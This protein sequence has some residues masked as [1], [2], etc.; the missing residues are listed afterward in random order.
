[1]KCRELEE[2]EGTTKYR[3]V[4]NIKEGAKKVP[5]ENDRRKEIPC[6]VILVSRGY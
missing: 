1:M 5:R 3:R 6:Y 4:E 2:R